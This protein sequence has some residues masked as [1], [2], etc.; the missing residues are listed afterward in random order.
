MPVSA[1]TTWANVNSNTPSQTVVS[2]SGSATSGN[3]YVAV[4]CADGN[5]AGSATASS[6]FGVTADGWRLQVEATAGSADVFACIL[7]AECDT[8]ESGT[9]TVDFGESCPTQRMVVYDFTT[10]DSTAPMATQTSDSNTASSGSSLTQNLGTTPNVNDWLV[11]GCVGN[12]NQNNVN[13]DTGWTETQQRFGAANCNF[14]QVDAS[15]GTSFGAD[16][17]SS[18][19]TGG[20]VI[21]CGQIQE[22]APSGGGYV[23]RLGLL[24]VG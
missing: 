2:P 5:A 13:P 4:A 12:G 17:N 1:P 3:L 24:G 15:N 14:Q 19:Q 21:V 10:F 6:T 20:I 22:T 23:P 8:T 16:W 18:D 7:Y 9:V 11:A